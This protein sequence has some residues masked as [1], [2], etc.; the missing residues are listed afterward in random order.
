MQKI[1]D[2]DDELKVI[3][4]DDDSYNIF[5]IGAWGREQVTADMGDIGL[6]GTISSAKRLARYPNT[7]STLRENQLLARLFHTLVQ[8][9]G[10]S[11]TTCELASLGLLVLTTHAGTTAQADPHKLPFPYDQLSTPLSELK[12]S[13]TGSRYHFQLTTTGDEIAFLIPAQPGNRW[14]DKQTLGPVLHDFAVKRLFE[15]YRDDQTK[16]HLAWIAELGLAV[17]LGL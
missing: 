9:L 4:A 1:I 15:I 16:E 10:L 13:A 3:V 5:Y 7:M 6:Q 8:N 14:N 2:V 12:Y 11:R 17:D